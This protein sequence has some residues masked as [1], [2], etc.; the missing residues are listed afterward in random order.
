MNLKPPDQCRDMAEIRREVSA[1][2][3]EIIRLLGERLEYVRSAVRFKPDEE[4]IRNPDHWS[5]FF[6]DRRHWAEEAGYDP[7]VIEAVY[8]RLYEYTVQ[9]QLALHAGKPGG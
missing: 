8:R 3:R 9:V 4:S 7:W 6:A 5:A 1:L 2:D